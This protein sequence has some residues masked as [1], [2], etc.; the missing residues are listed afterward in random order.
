MRHRWRQSGN[1][2]DLDHAVLPLWRA[3]VHDRQT[4]GRTPFWP[5]KPSTSRQPLPSCYTDEQQWRLLG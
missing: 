5:G 1:G 4:L 3:R 2:V